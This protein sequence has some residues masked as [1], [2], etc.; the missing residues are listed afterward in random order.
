V[1][2]GL[3]H[4]RSNIRIGVRELELRDHQ[5]RRVGLSDIIAESDPSDLAAKPLS[6][7]EQFDVARCHP[8]VGNR[9]GAAQRLS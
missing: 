5:L 9:T 2:A 4:G 7:P 8:C 1:Q 3:K 6:F